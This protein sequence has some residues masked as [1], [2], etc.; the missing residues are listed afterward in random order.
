M[1]IWTN[2]KR[3]SIILNSLR[4]QA[5]SSPHLFSSHQIFIWK[6]E[7]KSDEMNEDWIAFCLL[8]C[9]TFCFF[10]VFFFT[11]SMRKTLFNLISLD[12]PFSSTFHNDFHH[13]SFFTS[14]STF[15]MR[16]DSNFFAGFWGKESEAA[17]FK[18][19]RRRTFL[20]LL[21]FNHHSLFNS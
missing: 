2:L 20:I 11:D 13:N 3:I 4:F 17:A 5:D 15:Y 19:D 7:L 21:Y 10:L 12:L 16:F 1:N 18:V 9:S 14:I 8:L 6:L